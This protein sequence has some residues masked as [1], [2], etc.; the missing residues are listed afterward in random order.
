MNFLTLQDAPLFP[1]AGELNARSL[2]DD[3]RFGMVHFSLPPGDC[4]PLHNMPFEV[5]F[6]VLQGKG[7]LTV[8][9][10]NIM[11]SSGSRILCLPEARRGWRN[12]TT[13]EDLRVLVLKV[14][15]DREPDGPRVT[16]GAISEQK[17]APNPHG[18]DARR[19]Y[20]SEN[21]QC[22]VITLEPG[23]ELLRHITPVDA[24]FYV[25]EGQ[26]VVEIGDESAEFR[27]DT[28]VE[29]PRDIPHL[30]RNTGGSD[31]QVLVVKIPRPTTPTRFTV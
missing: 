16:F 12:Y 21:A 29:S 27:R 15:M 9:D 2:Y 31:L 25:L 8:D 3:D 18:V 11:V 20:D 4:I 22:S 1:G 14:K 23:R 13:D 10:S 26:G 5:C 7:T 30:W 6:I 17:P 24:F 19:I 28:L